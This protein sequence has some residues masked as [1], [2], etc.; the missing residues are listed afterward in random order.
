MMLSSVA[1]AEGSAVMPESPTTVTVRHSESTSLIPSEGPRKPPFGCGCGKCTFFSFTGRGC[2]TP[3]PSV[4]S[5]PYLDVSELSHEQQQYLMAKLRFE[6][7]KIMIRFQE[8]V[9]ATMESLIQQ[10][11]SNYKMVA[12]IMTLGTLK[13]VFNIP[14]IPAFLIRFKELSTANTIY[15]I[16][17]ILNDY[18]SFFIYHILEH[19]IKELGTEKDKAELQRYK[20]DFNQYAKRRIFECLPEFGPVSDSDHSDVFVKVDS[21]YDNYTVAQIEGFC[22]K[23]SEI[24]NVSQDILRLC[25]IDKDV[26]S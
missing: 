19:I 13:P 6:S 4:S 9:S 18:F 26:S 22:H 12:H 14:T 20:E 23:L 16:F 10:K 1:A 2:P 24:L 15:E 25:Q 8:L 5:F 11:I 17:L 7:E 21:H 3:I